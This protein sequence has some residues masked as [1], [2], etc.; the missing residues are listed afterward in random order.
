MTDKINLTRMFQEFNNLYSVGHIEKTPENL[1]KVKSL[2]NDEVRE[3]HAEAFER[4]FLQPG[5]VYK[6]K[7]IDVKALAFEITDVIYISLERLC[8]MGAINNWPEE[9]APFEFKFYD[10]DLFYRQDEDTKGDVVP[11]HEVVC[12]FVGYLDYKLSFF[13]SGFEGENHLESVAYIVINCFE[14]LL[15]H[16]L[17][18]IELLKAK[19]ASNMSKSLS[20]HNPDLVIKE[21]NHAKNRYPSADAELHGDRYILRCQDTKKVIKPR[22]YSPATI[23]DSKLRL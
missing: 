1:A 18:A 16:G 15:S 4:D 2:I 21:L 10:G 14:F 17:N 7:E 9:I 8:A 20:A 22:T 6:E 23:D 12:D 11:D 3:L 13:G 5:E 19:H